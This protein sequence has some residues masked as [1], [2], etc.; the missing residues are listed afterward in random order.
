M[1][2]IY[3]RWVKDAG[4]FKDMPVAISIVYFG[5]FCGVEIYWLGWGLGRGKWSLFCRYIGGKPENH[6]G[7]SPRI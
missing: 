6:H 5:N 1:L 4:R 7:K 2:R 3:G